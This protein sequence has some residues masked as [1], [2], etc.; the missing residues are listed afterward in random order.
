MEVANNA[1]LR[2]F[3]G[4][5]LTVTAVPAEGAAFKGWSTSHK[6]AVLE[7]AAALTTQVTFERMFSLTATFE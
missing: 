2:L 6:T 4:D 3:A 5:T 7:D 1:Q